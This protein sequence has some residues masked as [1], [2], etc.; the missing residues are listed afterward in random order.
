MRFI[1][2]RKK[3]FLCLSTKHQVALPRCALRASQGEI[4]KGEFSF[5]VLL[6]NKLVAQIFYFSLLWAT[7]H[8]LWIV[9]HLWAVSKY[10]YS[11][12]NCRFHGTEGRNVYPSRD[13]C[14]A[15]LQLEGNNIKIIGMPW[16][17]WVV[18]VLYVQ[19]SRKWKVVGIFNEK[20]FAF[21]YSFWST[22]SSCM[23]SCWVMTSVCK[24][25][26]LLFLENKERS[27]RR[28]YACPIFFWLLRERYISWWI[29][30]K[31]EFAFPWTCGC[32]SDI[33]F[34]PVLKK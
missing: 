29:E 22:N 34:S 4:L 18:D 19:I 10:F 15:T 8:C 13:S 12:D 2:V 31:P 6:Y 23:P 25:T 20:L 7:Q 24:F 32:D 14:T 5:C 16:R 30:T 27:S 33:P 1:Q 26:V 28:S 3:D 11:L 21:Y 9:M 17:C